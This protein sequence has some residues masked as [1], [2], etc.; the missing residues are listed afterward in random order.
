MIELEEK[1]G[2][3]TTL[4]NLVF[5]LGKEGGWGKK[6]QCFI[7]FWVLTSSLNIM[8]LLYQK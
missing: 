7:D 5:E 2:E 6:S 8:K 1:I 3:S 4:K